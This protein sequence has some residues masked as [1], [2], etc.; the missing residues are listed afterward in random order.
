MKIAH[1]C[2]KNAKG[3][4]FSV[5]IDE[6]PEEPNVLVRMHRNGQ[7]TDRF[8]LG[9]EELDSLLLAISEFMGGAGK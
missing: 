1:V 8:V 5:Q 6:I 4:L 9:I 3:E 2:I 7:K